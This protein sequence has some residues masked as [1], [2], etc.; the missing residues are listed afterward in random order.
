MGRL[1]LR[2]NEVRASRLPELCMVCGEPSVK[3]VKKNFSWYPPW[4]T[5]LIL[6]GLL[7]Y[8]IIAA[9]LSQ[10]MT[11]DVPLCARHSG[12]FWKRTLLIWLTLVGWLAVG[13]LGTVLV[14]ELVPE[15]DKGYLMA[16][17]CM[18]FAA[19]LVAVIVVVGIAQNTAI[20]PKE[21]TNREI[22]LVRVDN[23]FIDAAEKLRDERRRMRFP[24]E[25]LEELQPPRPRPVEDLDGR[26]RRSDAFR[27]PDGDDRLQRRDDD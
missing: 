6:A 8:L 10:R 23:K 19:G 12:H 20:R 5:A 4:V 17:V 2:D 27:A 21:I 24:E 13:V 7:P 16:G 9:V 26:P 11:V 22:T 25:D 15:P 1:R 18:G 14:T 3:H